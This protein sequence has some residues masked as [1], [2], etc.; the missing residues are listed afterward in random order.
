V[1]VVDAVPVVVENRLTLE[2]AVLPAADALT[3]LALGPVED[4][5]DGLEHGLEPVVV[6]QFQQSPLA[7]TG[8]AHHGPQVALEV[9][10][11]AHV[12]RHHLQH[13][14]PEHAAVV[15]LER[16]DANAF[17]PDLGGARVVGAV[18]GAADVMLVRPVDGPEHRPIAHEDRQQHREVGQVIVAVIGIVEEEEI[19][20]RDAV[21]EELGHR[22]HRPGQGAHVDRHVLGLGG[23]APAPVEYRGREVAARVEDLGVGGAEHR[24]AHLLHD[25]FETM[26]DDGDRDRIGRHDFLLVR[27]SSGWPNYT[28]RKPSRYTHARQASRSTVAPRHQ[29]R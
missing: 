19:A 2:D 13:V 20:G 18:G 12:G 9:A 23:Q 5:P 14:V 21:L 29:R 6:H 1:D 10:R 22:G 4:L 28:S 7:D 26:L 16:G 15:E 27:A 25:R 17:L 3:R 8:R 24:L 11:V